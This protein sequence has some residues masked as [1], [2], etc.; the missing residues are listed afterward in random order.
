MDAQLAQLFVNGVAVGSII[1]LAA[2][3]LTLTYGIL[4][5]A[6]FAHG[7]FMTLGAYLTLLANTSGINIWLSMLLG[8][9]GTVA[10]MLISEKLIWSNMRSRRATSTTLIIISIGLALFLR[11]GIIL[12]WGGSNKSYDIPTSPAR[13]I[14]GIRIPQNQ[15][16]VM[17]LAVIV[18]LALHYLLQNTK[19]GK[20]MR[21]VADNLDLARVSGIDVDRVVLWTWAIA[22][23]LTA[24]GGSMYG[25]ITAVRPNMGWFLILPMFA[26]TILGGIGNPYGAIAAALVIGVTQELSTPFLGSQYKQGVGLFIMIL[27]LLI[28]PKGLF[29]GTI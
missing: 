21:A 11:N 10:A 2:V 23:S 1:A 14:L 27:V 22:G 4:R 24:L 16:I 5:L 12:I 8:A 15:L 26:A 20:A 28:R 3:G 25:L 29:K 6:N 18:I 17:L 19:I 9:I 13:E 7:D